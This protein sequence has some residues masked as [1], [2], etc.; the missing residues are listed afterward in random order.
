MNIGEI[1]NNWTIIGRGFRVDKTR[2][3]KVLARCVCGTERLMFTYVLRSGQS[4]SCGC[5]KGGFLA[6]SKTTHGKSKSKAYGVWSSMLSRCHN[7]KT[8]YYPS[9]GGRG[10]K[11]CTEWREDFSLFLRDMGEPPPGMTIERI[12]NNGDYSPQNC[13]WATRKEQSANRR[14][15]V[16]VSAFGE[17]KTLSEWADDN[18]SVVSLKNIYIRVARGWKPE[19]AIVTPAGKRRPV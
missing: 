12:N 19:D 9:Y 8:P 7:I 11:V 13:R 3:Y 16:R 10:I 14:N 2:K 15:T 17:T 18:R 5:M 4:K 6:A 1:Y